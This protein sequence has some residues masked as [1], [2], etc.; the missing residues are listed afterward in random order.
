M[1][2]QSPHKVAQLRSLID[3]FL[4]DRL[5][6]KL[7]KLK[8]DA[9]AEREQ[10]VTQFKTQTWLEDAAHRVTQIQAVTHSLK[11]IHP[12]AKGSSLY[13][14]PGS[15][16]TPK[17][18]GSH[19]LGTHF[20]I[21]V[22]GNA[23]ALDVYKFLKLSLGGESL[24]ELCLRNDTDLAA[25]LHE[26]PTTAKRWMTSFGNLVGVRSN[27]TSHTQAKQV[28]WLLEG[29]DPQNS[30]SFHLLAPLYPT[31]LIHR[32][33]QQ[34]QEDRF[35]DEAK[36]AR[37]ARK[38]GEFSDR[39]V[40]DYPQLAVQ[41]L[42]GTKPQ[43]ISQLNSE[44][45]GDNFLFASLPPLWKALE[46]RAVLHVRTLFKVWSQR[47]EVWREAQ[48]LRKFLATRPPANS[49]TRERV[50]QHVDTLIDDLLCWR[51][52]LQDLAPGWSAQ[53]GCQLPGYQGAWLDT[54]DNADANSFAQESAAE[55]VAED[56][57]RW[58]NDQ[59]RE[60]SL[61]VGSDEF[62]EWKRRAIGQFKEQERDTA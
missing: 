35:S 10:L 47:R 1:S 45:R 7:D 17:V 43:N 59:L 41:K 13:C 40:R 33:Y 55:Q 30:A 16:A 34:V 23:A 42:G 12:D 50:N 5:D 24:L 21:D 11:P 44:R 6:A 58:L 14:E 20:D 53:E 54:P 29:E 8:E 36:A 28:F 51:A 52:S 60:Q 31:S 37:E 61:P 9:V 4:K 49:P 56:F 18:V 27:P 48:A 2:N 19:V 38:K 32:V 25:A 62:I 3:R 46:V 22:V 15:L 26:D 57:A 39:T